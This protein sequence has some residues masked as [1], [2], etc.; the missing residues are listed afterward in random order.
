[1]KIKGLQIPSM[2]SIH[3]LDPH[4]FSP[5]VEPLVEPDTT[6]EGYGEDLILNMC[7]SLAGIYLT[8]Y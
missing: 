3:S 6:M 5:L 8:I 4:E 7:V 1:M 2:D